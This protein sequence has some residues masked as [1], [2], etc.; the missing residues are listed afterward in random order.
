[1][2][3]GESS[4]HTS[5]CQV[6]QWGGGVGLFL[7]NPITRTPWHLQYT[8]GSALTEGLKQSLCPLEL[9]GLLF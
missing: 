1:L 4:T 8:L 7:F 9:R 6:G 5:V 3:T 2:I